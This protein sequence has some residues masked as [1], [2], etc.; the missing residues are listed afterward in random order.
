MPYEQAEALNR[1]GDLLTRTSDSRQARTHYDQA[2]ALARGVGAPL[3]QAWALEGI[4]NSCIQEGNPADAAAPLRQAL[5][6]YQRIGTPGN[7]RIQQTLRR[8]R[9]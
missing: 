8:F 5:A 6:I 2:L 7:Q 3:Q 1:L 9:L 4:G